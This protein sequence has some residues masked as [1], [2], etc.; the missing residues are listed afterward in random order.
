MASR[1]A[2]SPTLADAHREARLARERERELVSGQL[3]RTLVDLASGGGGFLTADLSFDALE[4]GAR[5][6]VNAPERLCAAL[7]ASHTLTALDLSMSTALGV[8]DDSEEWLRRVCEGASHSRALTQL[9]MREASLPPAAGVHIGAMLRAPGVALLTL[10]L[11]GN[12]LGDQGAR[13]IAGALCGH[14]RPAG[15]APL[16]L[17]TLRLAGNQVSDEGAATL[18]AALSSARG[19]LELD[20]MNNDI[21]ARGA[22]AL[23]RSQGGGPRAAAGGGGGGGGCG[24]GGGALLVLNCS[25]NTHMGLPC[26]RSFAAALNDGSCALTK[27]N[28][29]KCSLGREGV[30]VVAEALRRNGTLTALNVRDNLVRSVPSSQVL[31]SIVRV[32]AGVLCGDGGDTSAGVNGGGVGNTSLCVLDFEGS[33]AR[34]AERAA[35]A[36]SKEEGWALVQRR[37]AENLQLAQSAKCGAVPAAEAAVAAEEGAAASG[38]AVAVAA[39][40]LATPM[41]KGVGGGGGGGGGGGSSSSSSSDEDEDD[42]DGAASGV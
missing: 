25:G 5:S 19:L 31:D 10:D 12:D 26:A 15:A 39:A 35:G 41:S 29:R 17:R 4:R 38:C 18:A 13:A 1:R 21:G 6:I 24:A 40:P 11:S 33:T 8:L 9:D 28:L 2:S 16:P 3:G 23:A 36:M 30:A 42:G 20:L 27:L 32:V 34:H 14:R 22:V 37:L 7:R